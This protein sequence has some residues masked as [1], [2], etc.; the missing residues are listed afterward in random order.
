M[1]KK[2]EK[3]IRVLQENSRLSSQ[4]ISRKTLIP[5]TTVHHRIK[6]MEKEGIILKYTVK[7]DHK[8]IGKALAAY[9][10]FV[11]DYNYLR[12]K[13]IQQESLVANLRKHQWVEEA[14]MITGFKDCVLKVRVRDIDELNEFVVRYL[15]NAHG[16]SQT[17]TLVV[18]KEF[19]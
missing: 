16:I 9:V 18:L 12:D 1:D 14:A 2:D 13:K 19:D 11:P 4:Q 6:K 10:L 7:L 8:K 15:Q 17:E 3:I 5:V